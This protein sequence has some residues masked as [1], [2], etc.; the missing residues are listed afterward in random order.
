VTD[1]NITVTP[2]LSVVVH[3]SYTLER[4]EGIG[5]AEVVRT[6]LPCALVTERTTAGTVVE[7]T[8]D[9]PAAL[10]VVMAVATEAVSRRVARAELVIVLPPEVIVVG[11]LAMIRAPLELGTARGVGLVEPGAM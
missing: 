3:E 11:T 2:S 6:A 7:V 8:N 9:W 4:A 1:V 5:R 10:V